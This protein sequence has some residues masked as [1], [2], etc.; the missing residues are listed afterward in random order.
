MVS[1]AEDVEEVAPELGP[2]VRRELRLLDM[3]AAARWAAA[4]ENEQQLLDQGTRKANMGEGQ[5]QAQMHCTHSLTQSS[6]LL[7][8]GLRENR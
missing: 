8:A 4:E 2:V 6:P 5:R 7:V 3:A 1:E